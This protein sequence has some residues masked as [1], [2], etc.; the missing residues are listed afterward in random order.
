MLRRMRM[1]HNGLSSNIARKYLDWRSTG[2]MALITWVLFF[3]GVCRN[4]HL[5]YITFV[6]RYLKVI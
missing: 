2:G 4:G 6:P 5:G 3:W 1:I